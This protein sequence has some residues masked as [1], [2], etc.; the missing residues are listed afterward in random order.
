MTMLKANNLGVH[1]G[2]QWVFRNRSL[3][4]GE[5]ERIAL[6]GE[7]GSGK[8]LFLRCVCLLHPAD[9][10]EVCFGGK[11]VVGA[12]VPGFRRRVMYLPQT[13]VRCEGTVEDFFRQP[14]ELS[15]WAGSTFERDGCADLLGKFGRDAG[16]LQK[17]HQ[18][19]SGGEAQIVAL[20]RAVLLNPEVMLLDEP[21]AAMDSRAGV[22]AEG[23]VDEW[24]GQDEARAY[25][26]VS[27]DKAQ[28]DR[29]AERMMQF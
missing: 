21:A 7:S 11:Q 9:E 29:V 13:N 27:H 10:G 26:W 24:F 14:F 4:I 16:F 23:L 19:L 2:G 20:C 18:E 15:G 22:A 3:E 25:V 17:P 1:F 5:G 12:D 28:A 6:V 8:S